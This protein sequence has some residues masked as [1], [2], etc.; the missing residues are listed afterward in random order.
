[1]YSKY[2]Y[3]LLCGSKLQKIY[4][5]SSLVEFIV[6]LLPQSKRYEYLE[7]ILKQKDCQCENKLM[8]RMFD[9][10]FEAWGAHQDFNTLKSCSE[11]FLWTLPKVK[12]AILKVKN[13]LIEEDKIKKSKTISSL[14]NQEM[15]Y[16]DCFSNGGTQPRNEPEQKL[17][18]PVKY[19]VTHYLDQLSH[20]RRKD[21]CFVDCAPEAQRLADQ[22]DLWE[23]DVLDKDCQRR[24]RVQYKDEII[25]FDK[26]KQI[27]VTVFPVNKKYE[28]Y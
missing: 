4:D 2:S 13:V 7:Y 11:P 21:N 15:K 23:L 19:D 28:N 6:N 25:V 24:Y 22:N 8:D 9:Q 12:D 10:W 17:S 14:P 18:G 3:R 26:K 16:S 20:K 1:M 27:P 5:E